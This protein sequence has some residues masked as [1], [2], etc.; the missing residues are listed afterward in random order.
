MAGELH[1]ISR[2][3]D[4]KI[5]GGTVP[6]TSKIFFQ[7]S[8]C[9]IPDLSLQEFST[10]PQTSL[11][12]QTWYHLQLQIWKTL[13]FRRLKLQQILTLI[14]QTNPSTY[15]ILNTQTKGHLG[16]RHTVKYRLSARVLISFF[17]LEGGRLFDS[18]RLFDGGRLFQEEQN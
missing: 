6:L 8:Y 5:Y 16:Q 18:G 4:T 17:R 13:T 2:R 3:R 1:A 15:L 12:F 7:I 9:Q 11:A 14:S 10:D